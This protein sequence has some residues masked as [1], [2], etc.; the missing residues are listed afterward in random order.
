MYSGVTIS[1][2]QHRAHGRQWRESCAAASHVHVCQ[3]FSVTPGGNYSACKTAFKNGG[4]SWPQLKNASVN[5]S[6]PQRTISSLDSGLPVLCSLQ[7]T[8]NWS[9]TRQLAVTSTQCMQALTFQRAGSGTFSAVVAVNIPARYIG[10]VWLLVIFWPIETALSSIKKA[11]TDHELSSMPMN[12]TVCTGYVWPMISPGSDALFH[13]ETSCPDRGVTY[14]H[15][16]TS[17]FGLYR[18]CC[19]CAFDFKQLLLQLVWL[20]FN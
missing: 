4:T 1:Q 6:Y 5:I 3:S 13:T 9:V 18:V 14:Q 16:S 11:H 19:I 10:G 12:C 2:T 20:F 15:I 17:V 7:H 8:N